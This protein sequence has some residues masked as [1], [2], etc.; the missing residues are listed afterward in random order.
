MSMKTTGAILAGIL[1]VSWTAAATAHERKPRKDREHRDPRGF[2]TR[3]S[4][5]DHRGQ[6]QRDNGRPLD[7]LDLNARCDREEFW[8]RMRD[9]G[10]SWR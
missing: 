5:V 2:Y 8:D 6:C 9:R 4:T 1:A 7:K 3:P 10:N